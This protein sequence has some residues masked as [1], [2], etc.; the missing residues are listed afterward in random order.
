MAYLLNLKVYTDNKGSLL[1]INNSDLP[2][3]VKRV[4]YIYNVP[5]SDIVRGGHRHKITTQALIA[6]AGNCVINNDSGLK[7]E[8]FILDEPSKCLILSPEDWHTMEAFSKNCILMVLASTEY[9]VN[10]YID[11]KY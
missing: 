8:S 11:D 2:F 3:E 7:K 9:D 10:D 1:P 5:G 6:I 4:F